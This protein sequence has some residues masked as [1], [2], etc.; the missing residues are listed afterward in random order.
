VGNALGHDERGTAR[1]PGAHAVDLDP[2]GS[3]PTDDHDRLAGSL[4]TAA[5]VVTRLWEVSGVGDQHALRHGLAEGPLDDRPRQHAHPLSI[6]A[7]REFHGVIFPHDH[8]RIVHVRGGN[9]HGRRR[10]VSVT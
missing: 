6:E 4:G 3:G 8:R 1:D 2:A 9:G 10:R 7:I 5:S